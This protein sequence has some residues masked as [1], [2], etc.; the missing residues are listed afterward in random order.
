MGEYFMDRGRDVLLVIDDLTKHAALYRQVSLLLRRPPGREAFPGDVFY[1]HSRLLE[2]AAHL[3]P[4]LGGGSLTALPI[5]ETQAGNISAYIPTNIISITDGQL[6]LDSQL[7][8]QDQKPSVEVGKSVSRVGGATQAPALKA[9]ARTLKLEYAQFLELEV[10]TRFGAMID[11]RSR[12]SIE[13]GKRIRAVLSQPQLAPLSLGEQVAT[14]VALAS[15]VLERLPLERV[16]AFRAALPG[17]L[18]RRSPQ[19]A[20]LTDS[21]APLD[22]SARA[23]L[24]AS[25]T[26]LADTLAEPAQARGGAKAED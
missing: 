20:S 22:D 12:R 4:E 25:L 13:R 16:D 24:E 8:Y 11:E 7:F 15:G 19:V 23:Q 21:S 9:V 2:R 18:A 1:I 17:W 5:V 3:A 26:E 14:L 10:F 6:F